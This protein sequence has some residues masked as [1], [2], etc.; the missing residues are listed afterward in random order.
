[1]GKR[2]LTILPNATKYRWVS[3]RYR[4]HDLAFRSPNFQFVKRSQQ[5]VEIVKKDRYKNVTKAF[6]KSLNVR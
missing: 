1:M 5:T 6:I 3:V 2:T 4:G